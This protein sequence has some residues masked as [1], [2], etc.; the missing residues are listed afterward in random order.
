VAPP[1][2]SLPL[3][4]W[5][6]GPLSLSYRPGTPAY[7]LM[8]KTRNKTYCHMSYNSRS[9]LPTP[10]SSST[11]TCPTASVPTSLLERA[12]MLPCVPLHRSS[13]PYSGGLRCCHMPHGSGLYLPSREGSGTATCLVASDLASLLKRAMTLPRVSW[14]SVG[15]IP[16]E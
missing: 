8:S 5:A 14:I 13:P 10:E 6:R 1:V 2:G 15:H 4:R 7:R 11:A 12:P 9:H 16:Q 3:P